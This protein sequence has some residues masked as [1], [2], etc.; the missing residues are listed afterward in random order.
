MG[1]VQNIADQVAR[2]EGIE[3]AV[4][5]YIDLSG[6]VTIVDTQTSATEQE[7][8]AIDVITS[9]EGIEGEVA[10][11]MVQVPSGRWR[12]YQVIVA[13]GDEEMIPWTVP[14]AGE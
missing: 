3:E 13:G 2:L 11:R 9:V 6:E 7:E 14:T 4:A 10:F 12:V 8:D 5:F 1:S